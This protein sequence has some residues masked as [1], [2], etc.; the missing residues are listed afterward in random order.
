MSVRGLPRRSRDTAPPKPLWEGP[1]AHLTAPGFLPPEGRPCTLRAASPPEQRHG[2]SFA[3]RLHH[4]APPH[5]VEGIGDHAR[6]GCHT[7]GDHPAHHDVG[8]LGVREHAC[9]VT[10]R[11]QAPALPHGPPETGAAVINLP[12]PTTPVRLPG[13]GDV[14]TVRTRSTTGPGVGAT[15]PEH[16]SSPGRE[17][18]TRL[19]LF[20]GTT[21]SRPVP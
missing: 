13:P 1:R 11:R 16:S 9:G 18:A 7:L 20:P 4:H 3:P 14:G 17:R 2:T 21:A 8:V 10:P 15:V 6:H 19:R 5:G 12:S